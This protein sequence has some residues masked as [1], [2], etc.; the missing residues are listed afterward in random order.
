MI[1]T[2]KKDK[3]FSNQFFYKLINFVNTDKTLVFDVTFTDSCCYHLSS[4]D[5]TDINK[6]FEFSHG[7]HHNNS[8]RFG[9]SFL[10]NKMRLWAYC[11]NSGQRLATY[12][13]SVELNKQYQLYIN[14][15][16]TN[17]EFIV[18]CDNKI[19]ATVKVPKSSKIKF[20]YKLW[21]Y[22]GGN[23]P[24]PHNINIKLVKINKNLQYGNV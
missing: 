3:H 6:L 4:E 19:K 17:H 13:T 24:A 1:F 5:Q 10:D 11:Y 12:I 15:H 20:G 22:F 14:A 21:P 7:L 8:A 18:K 16:E 2:I 23:N 9:W